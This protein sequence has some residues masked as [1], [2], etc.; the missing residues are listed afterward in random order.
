M[1]DFLYVRIEMTIPQVGTTVHIAELEEL[2]TQ[3]CTMRRIIELDAQGS[4]QGGAYGDKMVGLAA[5]PAD[6]VPHPNSY[7]DFTDISATNLNADEF[8]SLWAEA[9]TKFPELAAL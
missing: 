6:V 1:T 4:I 5:P 2:N 9:I 7:G 8:E 3:M